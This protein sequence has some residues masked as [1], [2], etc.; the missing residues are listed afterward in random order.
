MYALRSLTLLL[1]AALVVALAVPVYAADV[2]RYLP[3]DTEAVQTFN[4]RRLLDSNL[5]K[6]HGLDKL[7]ELLKDNDEVQKV[8]SDLGLD[9]LK[10]V[11][12]IISANSG[13]DADKGIFIV[14]G[15]FNVEKFHA[16]AD[17][18]IKDHGDIVKLVKEPDGQRVYEVTIPE[19][20]QNVFVAI[21]AK[22]TIVAS[23]SREYIKLALEKGRPEKAVLK[24][25]EFAKLVAQADGNQV[26]WLVAKGSVFA[27]AAAAAPEELKEYLE[28]IDTITGGI[29]V[30]DGVKADFTIAAK[31]A[32]AAKDL[33]K[34]IEEGLNTAKGLAALV[35]ANSK[36][37][38]P[39]VDV[40]EN[41]KTTVKDKSINLKGE[42]AAAV[43][44]KALKKDQ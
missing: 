43:F 31:S 18:A 28:K 10:D 23:P 6:K 26:F 37:L 38:A 5:V 3:S 35:A 29:A 14:H 39:F 1:A 11:D 12:S 44:E 19:L 27:K 25:Q 8:L 16:K 22:D 13:A 9:P 34:K 15:R 32:D 4:L 20:P 33:A 24:N 2:D 40:V 21:A 42:V 17:E 36:E 41:I 30:T 7:Q